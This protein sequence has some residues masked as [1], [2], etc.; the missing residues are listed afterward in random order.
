V[1]AAL[2][3]SEGLLGVGGYIGWRLAQ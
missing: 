2:V 3:A 1:P